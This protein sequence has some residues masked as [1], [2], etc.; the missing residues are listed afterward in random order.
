[1]VTPLIRGFE[2]PRNQLEI[3]AELEQTHPL[4]YL[5]DLDCVNEVQYSTNRFRFPKG[6][7]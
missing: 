6:Y 3:L 5:S 1:M 4:I 2:V 7:R